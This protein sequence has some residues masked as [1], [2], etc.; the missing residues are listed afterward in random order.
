MAFYSLEL[1]RHPGLVLLSASSDLPAT[2]D[3]SL[4]PSSPHSGLPQGQVESGNRE[5]AGD[6]KPLGHTGRNVFPQ[7]LTV[8]SRGPVH[9]GGL[10]AAGMDILYPFSRAKEIGC[11]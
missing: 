10:F 9:A 5:G 3:I 11:V 7:S 6:R 1:R 2:M 8:L 4:S